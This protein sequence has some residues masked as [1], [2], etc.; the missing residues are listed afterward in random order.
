MPNSKTVGS[1]SK[2]TPIQR[3]IKTML[4]WKDIYEVLSS[5]N[6]PKESYSK[7]IEFLKSHLKSKY[8]N[9]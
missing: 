1:V 6:L 2:D 9:S 4:L 7:K 3:G 8:D 5:S